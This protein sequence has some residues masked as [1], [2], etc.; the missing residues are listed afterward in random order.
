MNTRQSELEVTRTRD[1]RTKGNQNETQLEPDTT[2]IK[3]N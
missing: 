2:R 1:T 3:C